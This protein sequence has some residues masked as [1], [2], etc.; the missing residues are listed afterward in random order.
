VLSPLTHRRNSLGGAR[1]WRFGL[2][3]VVVAAAAA[4]LTVA[5]VAAADPGGSGGPVCPSGSTYNKQTKKCEAPSVLACPEGTTYDEGDSV[6]AAPA[7]CPDGF[8]RSAPDLCQRV[9]CD[10]DHNCT[11]TNAAPTCPSGT[12]YALDPSGE[13][14]C[15]GPQQST[16]SDGLTLNETTG[17]CE[18]EPVGSGGGGVGSG[19]GGG[20]GTP[21]TGGGGGIGG[22]G[23]G[24]KPPR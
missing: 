17:L 19:G 1:R 4:A 8:T 12:G 24:G 13:L 21:G 7:S 22:G 9:I 15:E 11:V 3:L 10:A 5:P 6:C 20:G 16:C 18:A 2:G 23:G 14:R